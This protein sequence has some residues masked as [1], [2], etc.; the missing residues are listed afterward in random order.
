MT[1]R[2][3]NRRSFLA[4]GLLFLVP[5]EF[6]TRERRLEENREQHNCKS[7]QIEGMGHSESNDELF[8]ATVDRLENIITEDEEL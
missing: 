3:W 8:E 1:I 7:S 2:N 6:H 5:H 4:I